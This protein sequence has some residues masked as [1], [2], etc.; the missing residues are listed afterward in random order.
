MYKFERNQM[1]GSFRG[2][3]AFNQGGGDSQGLIICFAICY[4]CCLSILLAGSI[5]YA[6]YL[7][8]YGYGNPDPEECWWIKG[9]PESRSS[10][11]AVIAYGNGME[12]KVLG[13]PI[14]VHARFTGWFI[15]GFYTCL[16]PCMACPIL[17]CLALL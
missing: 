16:A 12:P 6:V 17:T 4:C 8:I 5:V 13:Q 9:L 15:W 7:G 14:D 11:E 10:E 1:M 2:P 3:M